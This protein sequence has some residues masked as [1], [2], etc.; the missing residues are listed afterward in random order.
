MVSSGALSGDD[1][2]SVNHAIPARA[3]ASPENLPQLL[4][5]VG[6][7]LARWGFTVQ[8]PI[9]RAYQQDPAAVRRWLRRDYPAIVARARQAR[10]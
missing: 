8:K 10:A 4:R 2:H 7:S 3:T 5:T 6:K 9:R 1:I